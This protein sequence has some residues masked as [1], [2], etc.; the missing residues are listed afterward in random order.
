MVTSIVP[1]SPLL[2]FP[3]VNRL[4][5]LE[6][7][8]PGSPHEPDTVRL[9]GNSFLEGLPFIA[10]LLCIS[11]EVERVN[12][13]K[14]VSF[15]ERLPVI[16]LLHKRFQVHLVRQLTAPFHQQAAGTAT[17][18]PRGYKAVLDH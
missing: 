11:V 10:W 14:A 2:F 7:P 1:L 8:A 6:K 12:G 16:R 9:R 4:T 5:R 3:R 18:M 13:V 15:V 17:T